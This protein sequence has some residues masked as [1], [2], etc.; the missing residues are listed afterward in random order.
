[1]EII[2]LKDIDRL[3]YKHDLVEVKP[4]FGRNFLIPTGQAVIANNANRAKLDK[5]LD[6]QE[7]KEAARVEEY[8]ALAA[9]IND[10]T[11]K[12][13][14]KTGTSGKI[15]GSVTNVQ[16]AAALKDQ[17]DLDIERRKIELSDEIKE[18]GDYTATVRFYKEIEANV[19][20]EL[21]KE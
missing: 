13:G 17:M 9:K 4:G 16:I 19:K 15:F 18:I 2:L 5:I 6:E 21:I 11:L 1:M 12:I 3:G 10:Q 7:A 20:L 8:K 14:V